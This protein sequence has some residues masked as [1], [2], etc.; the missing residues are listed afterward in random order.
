MLF[1]PL[2]IFMNM[3]FCETSSS[4]PNIK[5]VLIM[6]KKNPGTVSLPPADTANL[7]AR[8]E[9]VRRISEIIR[10]NGWTQMEAAEYCHAFQPRISHLLRGH[11]DK[12]S[13][14]A[15]FNIATR[16]GLR[17]DVHVTQVRKPVKP[18]DASKKRAVKA[19]RKRQ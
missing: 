10:A 1:A 8:A 19:P 4:S 2:L 13:L 18:A 15:L 7:T 16:L 11:I 3:A 17:V 9:L 6:R 5:G 14:D 12:F